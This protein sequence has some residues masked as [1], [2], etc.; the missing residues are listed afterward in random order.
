MSVI[1]M[2]TTRSEQLLWPLD[3]GAPGSTGRPERMDPKHRRRQRLLAGGCLQLPVDPVNANTL[4]PAY[5]S[6]DHL[7]P[8]Q[9]GNIVIGNAINALLPKTDQTMSYIHRHH[10]CLRW[11]PTTASPPTPPR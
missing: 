4:L 3:H 8:S 2:T 1:A 6:G 10:Q 11:S 5:D 9:A 7:H